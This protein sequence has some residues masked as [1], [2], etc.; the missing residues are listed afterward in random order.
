M[1]DGKSQVLA[2]LFTSGDIEFNPGPVT[3]GIVSLQ[4]PL[5]QHGLRISNV[6]GAGDCFFRVVSHQ[7]YGEPS[8]HM[9]VRCIGIQYMK[10]N[11][12][13]FIESNADHSWS[14]Y[15]AHMSQQGMWA[16]A[17]VVQAVV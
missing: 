6:G 2:K 16:D 1:Q 17:L 7:F 14:R 13:R 12:Q 9:N 10:N 8:C 3:Q 11:P 15:L 4:S 5:A